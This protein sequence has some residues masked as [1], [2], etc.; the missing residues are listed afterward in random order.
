MNFKG[1]ENTQVVIVLQIALHESLGLI[2]QKQYESQTENNESPTQRWTKFIVVIAPKW[3]WPDGSIHLIDSSVVLCLPLLQCR[4][5]VED[6]LS[7]SSRTLMR[8]RLGA[9]KNWSIT[10]RCEG[11]V[12]NREP[13][14]TSCCVDSKGE[15][16]LYQLDHLRKLTSVK[17]MDELP[18]VIG[19]V[20]LVLL[21][22]DSAFQLLPFFFAL[23]WI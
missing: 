10:G 18:Q 21:S 6:P 15:I 22:K 16:Q 2:A 19:F 8:V 13:S 11:G 17:F 7:G 5:K 20:F 23:D 3:F 9:L 1:L 14:F 4:N 12:L